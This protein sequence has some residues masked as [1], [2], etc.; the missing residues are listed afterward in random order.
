MPCRIGPWFC[1]DTQFSGGSRWR[2]NRF[3]VG[4]DPLVVACFCL[5]MAMLLR[6]EAG[7]RL[8]QFVLIGAVLG[9]SYW[10]KTVMFPLGLVVL[11]VA[12]LWR[13]STPGWAQ[14]HRSCRADLLVYMRTLD[15]PALGAEGAFHVW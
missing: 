6:L 10:V 7:A 14:R 9:T 5:V 15:L 13:R 3:S 11:A 12:Y 1:W 8:M 4:P 2:C